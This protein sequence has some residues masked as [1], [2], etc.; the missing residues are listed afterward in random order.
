MDTFYEIKPDLVKDSAIALGF[1]DG[2]H[3]GH[4]VVIAQAVGQAKKLK[5]T[6]A[7]V[8]FK[9]H[10]RALTTSTTPKL[11]TLLPERLELF[12]ALGVEVA[13]VLTFSEE[14]CLMTPRQYVGNCLVGALG[15]NQFPSDRIITL[16][17]IEKA[18]LNFW[19][20]LARRLR[21]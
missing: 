8:T 18:M 7:L 19:Q 9:D 1:F 20:L 5:V 12:S 13:L 10:P 16:G 14:I 4:E 11:L 6:P 17:A 21:L 15:P 2:V 3:P